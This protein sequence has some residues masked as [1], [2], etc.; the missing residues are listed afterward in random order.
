MTASAY[1]ST[2]S[3][4]SVVAATLVSQSAPARASDASPALTAAASASKSAWV[5]QRLSAVTS[6][7]SALMAA[8]SRRDLPSCTAFSSAAIWLTSAYE[9]E[10]PKALIEALS[11]A[12]VSSSLVMAF[13]TSVQSTQS[14]WPFSPALPDQL[15]PSL[16]LAS[17]CVFLRLS[18][19]LSTS[20][21][22]AA[23]VSSEAMYASSAALMASSRESPWSI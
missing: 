5:I 7:P 1:A 17:N 13:T 19:L 14:I 16:T 23:M 8:E 4:L 6:L 9:R 12:L 22:I 18:T 20:L 3:P 10:A 11:T 2:A 21:A 15:S